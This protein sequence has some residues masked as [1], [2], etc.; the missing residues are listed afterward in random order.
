ML[1]PSFATPFLFVG[2]APIQGE[3]IMKRNRVFRQ[4]IQP[5][6]AFVCPRFESKASTTPSTRRNVCSKK[7]VGAD[8]CPRVETTLLNC[9]VPSDEYVF[10]SRLALRSIIVLVVVQSTES[11]NICTCFYRNNDCTTPPHA[12]Q[13]GLKNTRKG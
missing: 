11:L 3:P 9:D 1:N 4:I 2:N 6:D 7:S 12:I 8:N 10:V 13:A 5:I